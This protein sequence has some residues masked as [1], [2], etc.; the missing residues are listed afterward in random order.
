[1]LLDLYRFGK[2]EEKRRKGEKEK[3][4]EKDYI[5][6]SS[7]PV[8][9]QKSQKD[10]HSPFLLFSFSP[11]LPVIDGVFNWSRRVVWTRGLFADSPASAS[12][13]DSASAI[14]FLL[15]YYFTFK[16]DFLDGEHRTRALQAL[17]L[18]RAFAYRSLTMWTGQGNKEDKQNSPFLW[19]AGAGRDRMGEVSAREIEGSLDALAQVAVHTGDPILMWAL[20]GSLSRPITPRSSEFSARLTDMEGNYKQEGLVRTRE[21]AR[22]EAGS[23]AA[24]ENG[25]FPSLIAPLQDTDARIVCGEKAALVF[26]RN[27]SAITLRNYRCARP[28]EFAFTLRIQGASPFSAATLPPVSVTITFPCVDLSRQNVAVRHGSITRQTLMEGANLTRAPDA[29]W[30][31]LVRGLREG[32]T[33]VVGK[34]DLRATSPL[35]TAPP[36]TEFSPTRPQPNAVSRVQQNRGE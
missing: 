19:E 20:Q 24:T 5:E 31:L 22:Q 8:P 14:A 28:G 9:D 35:P 15:D 32:D 29:C 18:A 13:G 25:A 6:G 1:M 10:S 4:S 12:A 21:T 17:E 2:E 30:S 34:P 27:S 36:L 11:F 23:R 3:R 26:N 33:V 16:D 7:M